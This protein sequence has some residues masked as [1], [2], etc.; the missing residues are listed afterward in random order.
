LPGGLSTKEKDMSKFINVFKDKLKIIWDTAN[1]ATKMKDAFIDDTVREFKK[2][3]TIVEVK[4]H[5]D[6]YKEVR[7]AKSTDSEEDSD[8]SAVS[9]TE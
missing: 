7:S 2:V 4:V 1:G 5:E 3:Q 6:K 8:D 9:A